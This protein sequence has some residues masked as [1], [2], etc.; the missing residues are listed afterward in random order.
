MK[1]NNK[2]LTKSKILKRYGTVKATKV[3]ISDF[4]KATLYKETPDKG[5]NNITI[6]VWLL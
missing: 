5:E 2:I 3:A 4:L 1:N 6:I